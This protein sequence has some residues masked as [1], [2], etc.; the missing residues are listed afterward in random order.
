MPKLMTCRPGSM[1]GEPL[2]RPDNLRKAIMLPEKVIAPMA[3]PSPSSMRLTARI[4]PAAST[5]P[6]DCGS[7]HAPRPTTT[8]ARP[9]RLWKPATS[10]GIAVIAIRRATTTP[11]T[12][13]MASAMPIST[14]LARLWVTSV[15]TSAIPIPIMPLRLP[16]RDVAGLDNPR[17]ARMK[18][19]PLAR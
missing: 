3:M 11:I 8:A 14:K 18:N 1:I 17:S 9:T 6:N 13:P 4:C 5:I 2:I 15:V 16:L 19:T 12:P 7:S 10:S